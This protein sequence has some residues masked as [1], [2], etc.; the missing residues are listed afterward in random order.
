L[1]KEE[2]DGKIERTLFP[3]RPGSDTY[4]L[5][6]RTPSAKVKP[7]VPSPGITLL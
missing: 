7:K 4:R 1:S 5:R 2:G 6:D 3:K